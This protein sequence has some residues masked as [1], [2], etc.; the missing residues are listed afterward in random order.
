M[1]P[2]AIIAFAGN[3]GTPVPDNA[4]PP[5]PPA[6]AGPHVLQTVEAWGWM[7]CDGRPLDCCAYPELFAVLGYLHGGQN[8]SFKLPDLRGYFLRAA[9]YGAGRA[10]DEKSRNASGGG[11]PG[12]PGSWQLDAYQQHEHDYLQAGKAGLAPGSG[13]GAVPGVTGTATTPAGDK[14]YR[15]AAETRPMNVYVH[16]LIKFAAGW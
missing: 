7:L 13:A 3:L 16:Y 9:D 12:Q 6:P 4:S 15:D 2:G 11:T 1:P 8:G 5:T 14:D 10:P